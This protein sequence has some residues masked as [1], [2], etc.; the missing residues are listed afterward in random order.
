MTAPAADLSVVAIGMTWQDED[1]G[2]L[3]R[4]LGDLHAALRRRG[5]RS[6]V[7]VT[8]AVAD[9]E[10]AGVFRVSG[11]LLARLLGIHRL[12]RR[13]GADA[14]VLHSHFALH[15]LLPTVAGRTRRLPL[16]T[17]FQ[18]PWA[19]ECRAEGDASTL[20]YLARSRVER[21]VYRRSQ[22]LV[23]LS[24]AFAD[25]LVRDYG[26]PP[27]RTEV[28]S[29][30]V[31]LDA[32]RPRDRRT[33]RIEIGLPADGFVVLSVR[34]LAERMGLD[35]LLEAW[36]AL[37]DGLLLIAGEGPSRKALSARADELG[38]D[39]SRVRFL[40][41]VSEHDLPLLYSAADV[42]VVPST[43]LE[44]FGLVVLESL[45]AGTPVVAT[46]VAGLAEVLPQLQADLLVP[47]GDAA[48]LGRRLAGAADGTAPLPGATTCRSFAEA[49]SWDRVAARF[50][51]LYADA[52]ARGRTSV[53]YLLSTA[54][55]SGGEL[56][57]LR[58]LVAVRDRVHPHV[59]LA[60]YGPVCALLTE[61]GISWEVLSLGKAVDARRSQVRSPVAKAQLAG[62]FALH[63]LRLAR[64]LR[65]LQPDLVHANSLK[66]GVYGG[67][68]SRLSGH[69]MVWHV[70]DR[71]A[72]DYLPTAAVRG[73]RVAV[74]RLPHAVVANSEATMRTLDVDARRPSAIVA[75]PVDLPAGF[76]RSTRPRPLRFV[77]V[78]RLTPWKGQDVL[79]RAFA[80]AFPSCDES[81]ELLVVGGA[82]F[83]EQAYAD[84]LT[85]LAAELGLEG[86][87]QFLGH[88]ADVW[89]LLAEA[90]VLVHCSVIPEPHGNV[91]AEGL[92]A[93][94]AVVASDAGGPQRLIRNGENGLLT[95]PGDIDALAAALRELADGVELR[96]RLGAAGPTSVDH[97]RP[98]AVGAELTRLYDRV[99][100]HSARR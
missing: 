75:S 12:V 87:A 43:Q 41:R 38:L 25:L 44:G 56:A 77:S 6:R 96:E 23:C 9:D 85:T 2:G 91:V 15:A 72:E 49:F 86:S 74:R 90:D 81:V 70:R 53:V 51:E 59:V 42:S 39:S 57:L 14:D 100:A 30:G 29:P 3:N 46:R 27:W 98:G 8:G 45:A 94:L 78:G 36:A 32:F 4:Y 37:P 60:E 66:A 7:A 89:E 47:P 92:A 34:R 11:S 18:G 40:G 82:L 63:A 35:V 48:A 79:L 69:P 67:L 16:V 76:T 10:A 73:L 1:P 13:L 61:A 20:R 71:L 80:K 64:R 52:V 31:D 97:L 62:S 95:P 54:Q 93:G 84:D 55:P 24:D 26:I 83:G 58:T 33:S 17:S 88:R 21:A 28:V 65:Q 99:M 5:L 22:V 50:Q 68:A 19:A